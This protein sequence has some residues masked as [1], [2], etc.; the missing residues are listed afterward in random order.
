MVFIYSLDCFILLILLNHI[1]RY[2]VAFAQTQN[3]SDAAKIFCSLDI[4]WFGGILV[5][6]CLGDVIGINIDAWGA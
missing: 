3:R 2:V 1:S 5:K 4:R 6:T